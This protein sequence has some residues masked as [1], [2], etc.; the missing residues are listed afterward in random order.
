MALVAAASLVA[1]GVQASESQQASDALK[2][3]AV[4]ARRPERAV[5]LAGARA[6]QRVIA[7]GE[8]GIILLSDD[9]GASW[10]QAPCPVSVTLTAVRFF[11]AKRGAAVGHGGV[12]LTTADAGDSWQPRLDGIAAAQQALAAAD[13][14]GDMAAR[15]AAERLVGDGADKPFLDILHSDTSRTMAVGAYGLAFESADFGTSWKPFMSRLLN[16]KDLHIYAVRRRGSIVLLAGEQGLLLWSEDDGQSFRPLN[17]PYRGSWFTAELMPSGE[18]LLA[19]LRGNVWRSADGGVTWSA[20][21]SPA[22]VSVTGSLVQ[23][24]GGVLLV[25]Q[26]GQI[27]R[28][29]GDRLLPAVATAYPPLA[30][31]VSMSRDR[32]LALGV[33]GVT[34]ITLTS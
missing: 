16:P 4:R 3:S 30:G 11:D 10:R 6:G 28:R 20:L 15:K 8:R 1:A 23:A 29:V 9:E 21:H 33:A 31:L 18:L 34:G 22:P 13:V 24:D 26:A 12:V 25:T 17:S 7:V 2:R 19:G 27:L 14:S 32:V 5:L